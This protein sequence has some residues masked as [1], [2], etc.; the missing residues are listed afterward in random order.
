[1]NHSISVPLSWVFVVIGVVGAFSLSS[2]LVTLAVLASSA[3]ESRGLLREIFGLTKKIEGLAVTRRESLEYEFDGLTT[4]LSD[5]VP[6]LVA[7]Q[8]SRILNDVESRLA[9]QLYELES[10]A[11]RGSEAE[12]KIIELIHSLDRLEETVVE[13]TR[14]SITEVLARTR[15]DIRL[16]GSPTL[17][18]L[19]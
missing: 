7:R 2:I 3:R 16:M 11:P 12:E 13:A 8:A 1:M 6:V 9:F 17:P 5:E 4:K 18:L 15:Q 19:S 14:Q 10:V